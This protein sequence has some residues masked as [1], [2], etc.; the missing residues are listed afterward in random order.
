MLSA[1]VVAPLPL[2][3]VTFAMFAMHAAD[4]DLLVAR[5]VWSHA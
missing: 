2:G 3:L 1:F 5:T 4:T